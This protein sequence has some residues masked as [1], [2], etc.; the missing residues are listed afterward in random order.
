MSEEKEYFGDHPRFKEMILKWN[1]IQD[2]I[3]IGQSLWVMRVEI[4]YRDELIYLDPD[5]FFES[6]VPRFRDKYHQLV[7]QGK[8][9]N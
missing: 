5:R 8:I 4:K 1:D 2:A 3:G 7:R 6:Y 9:K